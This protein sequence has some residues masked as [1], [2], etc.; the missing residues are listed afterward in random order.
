MAGEISEKVLVM[1]C[2]SDDYRLEDKS[3]LLPLLAHPKNAKVGD[4]VFVYAGGSGKHV[5]IDIL[6][7]K[8][9]DILTNSLME[10]LSI[11]AVYCHRLNIAKSNFY[12]PSL[13]PLP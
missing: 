11:L 7:I 6:Q 4:F 12:S 3:H 8:K 10:T 1:F 2:E 5:F 13:R 9:K